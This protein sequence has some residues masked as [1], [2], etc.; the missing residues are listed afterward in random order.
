MSIIEFK[1]IY[2]NKPIT[3]VSGWDS[4]TSYY[5]LTIYYNSGDIDDKIFYDGFSKLGFCRDLDKIKSVLINF[6][7][8]PPKQF[9]ELINNKSG[10]II[11]TWNNETWEEID[12]R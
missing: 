9:Y 11:Y 3:I 1:T 8:T 2:K 7:I 10:C 6:D 5:H 12:L 4:K